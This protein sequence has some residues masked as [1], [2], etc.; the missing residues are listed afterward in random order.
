[1][2]SPR[3]MEAFDFTEDELTANRAGQLS[4][5][6]KQ[7][8]DRQDL[9]QTLDIGCALGVF[10][11][12]GLVIVG[13]C[14]L[15]FNVSAMMSSIG[16]IA[17]FL[18]AGFLILVAVVLFVNWQGVQERKRTM[19]GDV[20]IIEGPLYA[21]L[22]GGGFN[23]RGYL[24]IADRRFRIEPEMYDALRVYG[25]EATFRVYHAHR[26][27][28]I[29]AV[30]ADQDDDVLLEDGAGSFG[31]GSGSSDDGSGS[32]DGGSGDGDAGFAT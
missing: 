29:V 10:A 20:E 23:A 11:V 32:F 21:T 4:P 6:Q 15:L 8:L 2:S 28:K 16:V 19:P 30:E 12:I 26:Y 25:Q 7:L 1:M 5:R 13:I 22:E 24:E 18:L 14:S 3:L 9:R 27:G 31:D 17:P